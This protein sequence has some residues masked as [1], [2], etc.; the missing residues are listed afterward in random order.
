MKKDVNNIFSMFR[1]KETDSASSGS[2]RTSILQDG[3]VKLI[4]DNIST[5]AKT[6]PDVTGMGLKDAVYLL[7]NMGLKVSASGRGKV[8]YQSLA[9]NTTFNK[10]ELIKIQL[11]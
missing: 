5:S 3:T 10:G 6:I 2:W 7:E 9:Q 8:I 1:Y 11:N 4:A